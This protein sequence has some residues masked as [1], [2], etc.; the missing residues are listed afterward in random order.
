MTD[1]LPRTSSSV[2]LR[3]LL[4]TGTVAG[5]VGLLAM[6]RYFPVPERTNFWDS[7]FDTGHIFLFGLM[8]VMF[9]TGLAVTLERRWLAGQYLIAGVTSL[10][11]GIAVEY[12]QQFNNRSAELIDVVNDLIGICAASMIFAMADWR[13]SEPRRGL[14]RRRWLFAMAVLLVG[15]G[16][17]PF[18]RMSSLY[19]ERRLAMPTLVKFQHSWDEI[20]FFNNSG[21]FEP[22]TAPSDWPSTS[23]TKSDDRPAGKFEIYPSARTPGVVVHEPYPDW[24]GEY[25]A[26]EIELFY[27]AKTPQEW[28]L[29]VHDLLHS[30]DPYDRFRRSLE[31]TPGFQTITVPLADIENAPRGRKMHMEHISA[32]SLFTVEIAEPV[33][34][35]IGSIRLT[36]K[37]SSS[38]R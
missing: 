20:F 8:A 27:E 3:L 22:T 19:R 11:I 33:S 36:E 28:I 37:P 30:N 17:L 14:L 32:L 1:N 4:L 35:T 21:T 2:L 18:I 5:T 15:L 38:G 26:L 25:E 23:V 7:V 31:L 16:L 6:V 12:W 29:R 10:M 24:T 9:L 13:L 34:I